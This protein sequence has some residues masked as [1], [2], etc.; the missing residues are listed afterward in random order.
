MN[1]AFTDFAPVIETT[2]APVPVHPPDQPEN[3][4]P[5]PGVGVS[6]TF[7]FLKNENLQ[8]DP[9]LIPAGLLVSVPVPD[10]V[11]VRLY[12]GSCVKVADTLLT[13]FIATT[14][15]PVPEHAPPQP[16]NCQPESGVAVK[17]TLVLLV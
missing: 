10:F 15:E 1:V 8:V 14:H 7:V 9:Q 3:L 11:T 12:L 17:V 4:Y 2:Q 5:L 13:A 6:V 16:L